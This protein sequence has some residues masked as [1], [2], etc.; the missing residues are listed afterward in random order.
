MKLNKNY[1]SIILLTTALSLI[2]HRLTAQN[3]IINNEKRRTAFN[4][5]LI[6][7]LVVIPLT[8]NGNT[9]LRFILDTGVRNTLLTNRAGQLIRPEDAQT[10]QVAGAG[11]NRNIK[12]YL[13]KDVTVSLPGIT[14]S[15]MNIVVLEE[16]Y[17][18]LSKHLGTEVHGIIGYDFFSSFVVRIDYTN[19]RIIVFDQDRFRPR[20]S[21]T[22]LPIR[23]EQG[24]PYAQ[25]SLKQ[26]HND[27]MSVSLLI[28]SGASHGLM[29]ER[30]S[31]ERIE[32]PDETIET[33][34][35]WGLGGELSGHLGRIEDFELA[36]FEFENM[37]SS[38]TE[39]Y[40]DPRLF[41][42]IG[43]R[44]S[45]GGELLSRFTTTY[46]YENK[47]LYLHKNY[48]FKRHFEFNLSGIDLVAEGPN[49][50]A[51]RIIHVIKGSAA[52]AAGLKTGDIILRIN[53]NYAANT[54]L[55]EINSTLRLRPGH[56]ISLLVYRH[57]EFETI[58]FK[59]QRLI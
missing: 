24:R 37:L 4:F 59:L 51:F 11:Q 44:G 57:G 54:N 40:S 21:H 45:L 6:N 16:D 10:V 53:G 41:E 17:L 58:R 43:R 38:F 5:E 25:A 8:L 34:V 28:D 31:D 18:E 2:C 15:N 55:S 46:D 22:P 36:G 33:I 50:K 56:R 14:G 52:E 30:D 42:R 13:V 19:K 7:N 1:I 35:G 26:M 23:I 20:K 49:F 48:H 47:L 3:F 9:P 27:Q 12:A 29:L 39:S 32:L